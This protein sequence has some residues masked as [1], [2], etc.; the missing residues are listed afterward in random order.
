[1]II[2]LELQFLL[3]QLLGAE[4]IEKHFTLDR[5][6]SGPDHAASLEPV[7]LKNMVKSIR[8]IEKACSGSGKKNLQK[9]S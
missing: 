6:M 5:N 3:E 7:E 8:E 4:V 9:V 1:M 2:H